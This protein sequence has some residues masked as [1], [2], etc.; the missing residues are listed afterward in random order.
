VSQS[1]A[2]DTELLDE[3]DA[4]EEVEIGIVEVDDPVVPVWALPRDDAEEELASVEPAPWP[5]SEVVVC[6]DV[7]GFREPAAKAKANMIATDTTTAI[8]YPDLLRAGDSADAGIG[9]RRAAAI[10]FAT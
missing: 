5:L 3:T 7:R 9:S 1:P 2:T 6:A 4:I 8:M 10:N